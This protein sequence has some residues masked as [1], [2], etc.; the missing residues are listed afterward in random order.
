MANPDHIKWLREGVEAWN[1]RREKQHFFPDF[2]EAIIP[3]ELRGSSYK[4][5]KP[6]YFSLEG[7]NLRNADFCGAS[8]M[9]L[10][11]RGVNLQR[12]RLQGAD[13]SRADLSG[14]DLIGADFSNANLQRV[15][16][17]KVV[18]HETR[19]I[20]A[21]LNGA[22]LQG[23]TG[24][25]QADFTNANLMQAEIEGVNF[26]QATLLG[27]NIA[28]TEFRKIILDYREVPMEKSPP[29]LSKEIKSI[30]HIVRRWRSLENYYKSGMTGSSSNEERVLYF[31]GE[32][33]KSWELR[34]SVMRS[35][36][37]KGFVFRDKEGEMLLDLMSQR[38]EDFIGATSA[39]SQLVLAQ[40]HGLKTRLL[41]LTRN[42]LVALFHACKNLSAPDK[43]DK[44]DG[45]LH[46]FAV[47]KRLVRRF[48]SDVISIIANFTKLP[49][50]E[51][52]MLMGEFNPGEAAQRSELG[53]S[54]DYSHIMDRL[55]HYIRQEKPHFKE[56]IDVRDLFKVFIVEPQQSFE[57]IKV[58][59]GAF[60]ISAFHKRFEKKEILAWNKYIPIYDHYQFIVPAGS[61]EKILDE[62]SLHN[63]R[64][65]VLFPDLDE[66]AEAIGQRYQDQFGDFSQV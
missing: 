5:P 7:I 64:R 47:P 49:R 55:Y 29:R 39:L 40:H 11:L 19:F 6:Y 56:R 65:E 58:Q 66:T 12:A 54:T 48:D 42:P 26:R 59:S 50:F 18:A 10:D 30:G 41:D 45:I 20:G 62:L 51:Q 34:P 14:A 27:A 53:Y 52:D 32:R 31:R 21:N 63:V 35:F 22:K 43:F 15:E 25:D 17:N 16:F 3:V 13:L 36:P 37:K 46:V 44:E 8:L 4:E 1:K 23:I 2:K 60:I 57:R 24:L 61:K 9:G 33:A 28:Y 38:P